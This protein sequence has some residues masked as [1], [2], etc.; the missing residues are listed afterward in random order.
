MRERGKKKVP[1][2]ELT[3]RAGGHKIHIYVEV[4]LR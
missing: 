1:A 2:K 3:K 4:K